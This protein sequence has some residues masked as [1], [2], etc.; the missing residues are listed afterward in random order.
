MT[1]NIADSLTA[2]QELILHFIRCR[3][4]PPTVRE[5]AA[6]FGIRSPNGV[7]HHLNVLVRKGYIVRD[8]RLA[9]SIHV[10]PQ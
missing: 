5:I 6:E 1:T 9:R 8:P 10:L 4:I 7:M 3:R 2:R